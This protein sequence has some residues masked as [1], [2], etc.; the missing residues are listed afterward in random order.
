MILV[1]TSGTLAYTSARRLYESCGY[2]YEAVIHDFYSPGD[3][4]ILFSKLTIPIPAELLI[5]S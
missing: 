4:L 2:R 5:I 3:D 1:E